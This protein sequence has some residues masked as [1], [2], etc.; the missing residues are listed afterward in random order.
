MKT[1]P[2]I[3]IFK[4]AVNPDV[5]E[6]E[7]LKAC[8][9]Q[10]PDMRNVPGFIDRELCKGDDGWWYDILHWRSPEDAQNMGKQVTDIPS[11]GPFMGMCVPKPGAFMVM[12]KTESLFK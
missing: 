2:Y 7:F 1:K 12:A 3:Q 8:E 4:F 10:M 11:F 6:K 9:E 5:D